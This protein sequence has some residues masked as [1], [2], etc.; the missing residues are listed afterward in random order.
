MAVVPYS[1]AELLN[2]NRPTITRS[3]DLTLSELSATGARIRDGLFDPA[4]APFIASPSYQTR[5]VAWLKV[6]SFRPRIAHIRGTDGEVLMERNYV[7]LTKE[8]LG[9]IN[10]SDGA[11]WTESDYQRL[12]MLRM[13]GQ[14]MTRQRE[15]YQELLDVFL[16]RPADLTLGIQQT[17]L[18]MA[19]RAVTFGNP[20]YTDP[21]SGITYSVDYTADIPAGH[22]AATL[23]GNDRWSQLT[24]ANGI[25]DLVAHLNVFYDSVKRFPSGIALSRLMADNLRN[26]ASTKILVA[27]NKGTITDGAAIVDS[28]NLPKASLE[29]IRDVIATELTSSNATMA[30]PS[31]IVTDAVYYNANSTASPFLPADYYVFLTENMVEAARVP[32][33]ADLKARSTGQGT[34]S[35]GGYTVIAKDSNDIPAKDTLKVDSAGMIIIP[36]PRFIGARNVEN[37]AV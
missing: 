1:V 22:L 6:K 9:S 25:D 19:L 33:I 18:L 21:R 29:D 5:D 24:T 7:D 26:Q 12:D 4:L 8:D 37:T 35:A 16:Q 14:D 30:A 28:S 15:A 27:R 20:N 34:L 3:I 2:K 13:L 23:A 36:D 31:I 32:T 10:I 11:V 17:W